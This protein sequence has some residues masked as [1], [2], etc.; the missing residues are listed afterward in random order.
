MFYFI[1]IPVLLILLVIGGFFV[2]F[3]LSFVH[4]KIKQLAPGVYAAFGGGGNSLIVK[5]GAEVLL[6][7]TKFQPVSRWLRSWVSRK[8][9]APVTSIVNTHYHYDHTQGNDLYPEAKIL[10]HVNVPDL[11]MQRDGAWWSKHQRGVPVPPNLVTGNHSILMG[12]EHVDLTHPGVAHTHGDL[13]LHLPKENII[14]TGDLF[15]HTYYPFFDLGDGGADILKLAKSVR[16]LVDQSPDAVFLP[17]HGPLANAEDLSNFADYL[18][19]LYSAVARAY[20]EGLS[21]KQMVRQIDLS[22][23]NFKILPSFHDGKLLWATKR[24][25]IRWVYQLLKTSPSQV[26]V[27]G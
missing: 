10:A 19:F 21:E 15:F 18:E 2:W 3:Y 14:V 1:L 12:Y 23:W 4:L 20:H 8:L 22:R 26:D 25:N 27:A 6:V 7:D 13:W 24:N 11:M 5:H 16:V 17:G 9:S